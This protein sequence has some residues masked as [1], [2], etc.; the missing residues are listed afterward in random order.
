MLS[1]PDL[2][3]RSETRLELYSHFEFIDSPQRRH[4]FGSYYRF[5]FIDSPQ[6]RHR[7]G[8]YYRFEFIDSPQ[9][10][11]RFGS[12]YRFEFIDSPQRRHRFGSYYRCPC[13][14]SAIW[15]VFFSGSKRRV[16]FVSTSPPVTRMK[17]VSSPYSIEWM[18]PT[19]NADA[20]PGSFMKSRETST[21]A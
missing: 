11:H 3:E 18:S 20:M 9:R 6:R 10:R 8:S 17:K 16:F 14:R 21:S 5:E 1:S 19:A 7:F 4:R 12:Y 15:T 2:D 13:A